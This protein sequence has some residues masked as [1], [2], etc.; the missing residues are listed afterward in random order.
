MQH[1]VAWD[2]EGEVAEEKDSGANSVDA[3]AEFEVAEHLE[4]GETYVDAIYIRDDI[5]DDDDRH[6]AP[7][8]LAIERI[9]SAIGG[10]VGRDGHC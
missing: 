7:R 9:A 1:D 8:D 3:F 5:G 6:D 4:L 2:F 10:G